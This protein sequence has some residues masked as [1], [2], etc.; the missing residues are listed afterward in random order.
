MGAGVSWSDRTKS[1]AAAAEQTMEGTKGPDVSDELSANSLGYFNLLGVPVI[2]E[3]FS[4]LEPVTLIGMLPISTGMVEVLDIDFWR[5]A[6]ADQLSQGCAIPGGIATIWATPEVRVREEAINNWAIQLTDEADCPLGT[7]P[8]LL[9]LCVGLSSLCRCAQCGASQI[10]ETGSCAECKCLVRRELSEIICAGL[11]D[12]RLLRFVSIWDLCVSGHHGP[13]PELKS[14]QLNYSLRGSG[15]SLRTLKNE[16]LHHGRSLL[17]L[18]TRDRDRTGSQSQPLQFVGAFLPFEWQWVPRPKKVRGRGASEGESE[19]I[20]MFH[21]LVSASGSTVPTLWPLHTVDLRPRDLMHASLTG[22][23]M[24][25]GTPES[26]APLVITPDLRRGSFALPTNLLAR[27]CGAG[28]AAWASSCRGNCFEPWEFD[29]V[30]V[31][32]WTD[33]ASLNEDALPFE[34]EHHNMQL[35]KRITKTVLG[36]LCLH[37]S[38][39]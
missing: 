39:C 16:V 18:Q 34:F 29:I 10:L 14:M 4:W 26:S 11:M 8:R 33:I 2:H 9:R 20:W 30:D 7:A 3:I 35:N 5:T 19:Q 21:I 31:E 28:A 25:G 24:I 37:G 6:L 17:V 32:V 13:V 1:G 27:G 23:V 38:R 15:S 12:A 36:G 22:G